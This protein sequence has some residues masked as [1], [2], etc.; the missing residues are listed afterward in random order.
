MLS[1][2]WVAHVH[3]H[4]VLLMQSHTVAFDL[5]GIKIAYGVPC[6]WQSINSSGLRKGMQWNH[7]LQLLYSACAPGSLSD[8]ACL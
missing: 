1:S 7:C 6:M 8:R 2:G 5:Y 4:A 3:N